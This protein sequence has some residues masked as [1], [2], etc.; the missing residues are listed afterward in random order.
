MRIVMVT[1]SC[2]VDDD[3]RCAELY[4]S[5]LMISSILP[6][7]PQCLAS[8][9]HAAPAMIANSLEAT[10][11]FGLSLSAIASRKAATAKATMRRQR[12]LEESVIFSCIFLKSFKMLLKNYKMKLSLFLKTI[13]NLKC[14]FLK[15]K[16]FDNFFSD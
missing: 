8:R 13:P 15:S 5:V 7:W 6:L 12:E 14:N 16:F 10:N 11:T 2:C 1:E 9:W 3:I 4:S